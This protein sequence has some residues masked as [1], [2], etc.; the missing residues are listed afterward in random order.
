MLS[1]PNHHPH[2]WRWSKEKLYEWPVMNF[3]PAAMFVSPSLKA[4][5]SSWHSRLGHPSIAILNKT[6]SKFSLPV[7]Q[8]SSNTL[9]CSDCLINK[10]HKLSFSTSSITSTR[11]LEI[12]F[13]D[14]WSSPII[15]TDQY[16]YYL[17]LVDHFTK[18]TWLYP[19][20]QKSQVK[21]IFPAYK[22][23]VENRFQRRIGTLFTDNGGEFMVMKAYLQSHGI[24][25][26]TSPP[27]TPEHN[28]AAERKHRHV[29]ETGLTLMS[30]ASMPKTY[31]PFAF[32]AAIYL[33]NRLPTPN[34]EYQSPYEKLFQKAPNYNRLRVFGC[35]LAAALYEA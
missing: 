1:T 30:Q 12:I 14:V 19:L 3:V 17:I 26:L 11:P 33:I 13:S 35:P 22:E 25:H 18:N 2:R 24:S 27:H 21:E 32:A 4:T 34:L 5:L 28:G 20:K 9:S 8:L 7:S 31:W 16:K 23:L 10:S 6:L 15:S 29:V